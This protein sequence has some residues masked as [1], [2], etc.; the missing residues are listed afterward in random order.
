MCLGTI[1][2]K[3]ATVN[4]ASFRSRHAVLIERK[5]LQYT[6]LSI[7]L[8]HCTLSGLKT[9]VSTLS[10][11][12]GC[13]STHFTDLKRHSNPTFLINLLIKRCKHVLTWQMSTLRCTIKAQALKIISFGVC[14]I[15]NVQVKKFFC[16][17]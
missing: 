15:V 11:V 8:H 13:L 3:V 17:L 12:L 10:F 4:I 5:T 1:G 6:I 14:I 2:T 16:S 7:K 9:Q